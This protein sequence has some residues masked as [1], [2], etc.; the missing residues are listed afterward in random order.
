MRSYA[1]TVNKVSTGGSSLCVFDLGASDARGSFRNAA[2]KR[3]RM[4]QPV[5]PVRGCGH[6][7]PATGRRSERHYHPL[8][9]GESKNECRKRKRDCVRSLGSGDR[10]DLLTCVR[11]PVRTMCAPLQA[12]RG[13]VSR[14]CVIQLTVGIDNQLDEAHRAASE[15]NDPGRAISICD[16]VIAKNPELAKLNVERARIHELA[17]D[18]A[19]AIA[20]ISKAIALEPGEPDYYFNRARWYLG[21]GEFNQSI[22]DSTAAIEI[23]I[24]T[25]FNYYDETSHFAELP[26]L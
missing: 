20:D 4:G 24:R 1:R 23:G 26:L 3:F 10:E 17:G 7:E 6:R 25:G 22:A 9:A 2:A 12:S 19:N 16:E 8:D 11:T 5:S 14:R 15:E 18:V 21:I 13:F